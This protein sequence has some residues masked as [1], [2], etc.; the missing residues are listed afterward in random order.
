MRGAAPDR[1]RC[2]NCKSWLRADGGCTTC[3]RAW[4]PTEKGVAGCFGFGCAFAGLM[5]LG[6]GVVELLTGYNREVRDPWQGV[7]FGVGL[8]LLAAWH[9]LKWLGRR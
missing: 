1:P 5:M 9:L 6:G 2:T 8:L 4:R 7:V 3:D